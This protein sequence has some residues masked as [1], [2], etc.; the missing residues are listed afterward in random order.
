MVSNLEKCLK[1]T[2]FRLR[3]YNDI[4]E[5]L[6]NYQCGYRLELNT[7]I[8]DQITDNF[9][10]NKH[11]GLAILDIEKAL[12]FDTTWHDGVLHKLIKYEF[13][14]HPV[15]TIKSYPL[16][17]KVCIKTPRIIDRKSDTHQPS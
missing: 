12:L 16:N 17:R 4:N 1:N 6:G 10:K 3:K 9:N 11:I 2:L 5:I 14:K 8:C 7:K 13:P 15:S